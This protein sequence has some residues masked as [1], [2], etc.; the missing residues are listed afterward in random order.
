MKLTT[1]NIKFKHSKERKY[2]ARTFDECFT[3]INSDPK[4]IFN[5]IFLS[6]SLE[7]YWSAKD[8]AFAELILFLYER[9]HERKEEF[10]EWFNNDINF[11]LVGY[12][13]NQVKARNSAFIKK[14]RLD[15]SDTRFDLM[16]EE[17]LENV[18]YFLHMKN[19]NEPEK[20][21]TLMDKYDYSFIWFILRSDELKKKFTEKQI[22]FYEKTYFAQLRETHKKPRIIDIV[23]EYACEDCEYTYSFAVHTI[24]KINRYIKNKL[25]RNA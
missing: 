12:F 14:Y 13:K 15:H 3:L 10:T 18:E 4:N 20:N 16:E 9:N 6:N 11:W 22:D 1:D 24:R 5:G 25:K 7:K 8:D 19:E 17:E 2:S 23:A 21:H